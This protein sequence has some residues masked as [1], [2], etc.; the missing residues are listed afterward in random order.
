METSSCYNSKCKEPTEIIFQ[1]SSQRQ[2]AVNIGGIAL[3]I[4]SW[5]SADLCEIPG[6]QTGEAGKSTIVDIIVW[7]LNTQ[8]NLVVELFP[9]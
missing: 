7:G 8:E 1:L 3:Y 4:W 5:K 2:A 9:S 6:L